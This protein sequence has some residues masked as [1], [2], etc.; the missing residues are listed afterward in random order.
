MSEPIKTLEEHEQAILRLEA[1]M[2]SALVEGSKES[3]EL[4]E[5]GRRIEIFEKA[6]FPIGVDSLEP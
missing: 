3:Q 6:M 1:L 2:I 4:I 5:L